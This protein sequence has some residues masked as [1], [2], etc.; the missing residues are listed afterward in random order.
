MTQRLY[1]LFDISR[2]MND[3]NGV[4]RPFCKFVPGRT[5]GEH[6]LEICRTCQK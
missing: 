2:S 4:I 3:T 5:R 6:A 1:Y